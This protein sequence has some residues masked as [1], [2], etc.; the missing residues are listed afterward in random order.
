VNGNLRAKL[1]EDYENMNMFSLNKTELAKKYDIS[2][3][4]LYRY[5]REGRKNRKP[6][7]AK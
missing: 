2:E 1:F 6:D 4:T 7:Y 3:C 5:I